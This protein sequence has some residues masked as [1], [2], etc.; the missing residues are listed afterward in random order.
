[1]SNYSKLNKSVTGMLGV[2]IIAVI[3]TI[4]LI[5]MY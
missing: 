4:A 2:A 1:M 5:V 3:I